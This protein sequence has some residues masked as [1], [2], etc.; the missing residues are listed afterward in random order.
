MLKVGSL[1]RC[2]SRFLVALLC[3]G[4]TPLAHSQPDAGSIQ[5]D[6]EQRRPIDLPNVD[7]IAPEP[8]EQETV[9]DEATVLVRGFTFLGNTVISSEEMSQLLSPLVGQTVGFSEL[10]KSLDVIFNEY[11]ARDRVADVFL[12]EQDV[13]DGIVTVQVLEG[14][15]G[16]VVLGEQTLTRVPATRLVGI[17]TRNQKIGELVELDR[18]D[19]AVLLADDL[20]GIRVSGGLSRGER[21]AETNLVLSVFEEPPIHFDYSVDNTGLLSTGEYRKT[22]GVEFRSLL[23]FGESV[24]VGALN[25]DGIQY[26]DIGIGVPLGYFGNRLDVSY[27]SMSYRLTSETYRD[28][29]A[30][31]S[32]TS[33]RI[34][35]TYA[36]IRS[37]DRN[38]YLS[39]TF[40]RKIFENRSLG[41]LSSDY[42]VSSKEFAISGNLRDGLGRGGYSSGS[43]T[44]TRGFVDLANS[45]NFS[46]D[47]T[48]T[49]TNGS[50]GKYELTLQRVQQLT[51]DLA[52]R[53]NY[54]EQFA[55]K[56]LD[57]SEK[58]YIG[59]STSVRAYPSNE[60]GGAEGKLFQASFESTHEN[61]TSRLFYDWG[62][63]RVNRFNTYS[64]SED[65]NVIKLVG[66]GIG[67][68][69]RFGK[70]WT[71]DVQVSQRV[72]INPNP[73]DD[74]N[75]QDGTHHEM[76]YWATLR[77]DWN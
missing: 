50:Y 18:I 54:T 55:R 12:P 24:R 25:T 10:Q 7:R 42:E 20:A 36:L 47:A 59:G 48:T 1:R 32:S 60:A 75:D 41:S 76:R 33:L 16:G 67:Q 49:D 61:A 40:N 14:V 38:L 57:S 43:L 35:D 2:A 3:L 68:E 71:F 74:G 31:G 56:N 34:T 30:Y 64:G 46:S 15:F 66:V 77:Y 63:V 39:A 69:F 44:Y 8:A 21:E 19:R 17:M 6:L 53:L 23:G 29:D 9:V 62:Q 27:S 72:G 37:G 13:T 73:N 11:A 51:D 70:T 5:K 26:K 65:P 4:I 52:L 22:A 45:P 28:L 58:M